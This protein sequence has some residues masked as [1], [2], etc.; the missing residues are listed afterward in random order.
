MELKEIATKGNMAMRLKKTEFRTAE[1]AE[2]MIP[3]PASP[4]E[5]RWIIAFVLITLLAVVL[6]VLCVVF[7]YKLYGFA[8]EPGVW[9]AVKTAGSIVLVILV[10]IYPG[11]L[12]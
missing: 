6:A 1:D 3:Q 8:G 9:D 11:I 12:L 2:Q 7:L 4:R 5:T 10:L